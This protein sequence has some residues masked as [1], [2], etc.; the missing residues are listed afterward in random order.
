MKKYLVE[1]AIQN[2][3]QYAGIEP[4]NSTDKNNHIGDYVD[5][6]NSEE[7]IDFAIDYLVDQIKSNGFKVNRDKEGI[8]VYDGEKVIEYYYNFT[9][10][11][12]NVRYLTYIGQDSWGRYT[13]KDE[14]QNIWKLLDCGS[15]R[16]L[17]ET[18][19]DIPYSVSGNSYDGEP[20]FPMHDFN[21]I[22][23]KYD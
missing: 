13:Y 14:N 17:C 5:A 11:P 12:I 21:D 16:R 22:T 19:G 20:E 4:Y 1:N 9:A 15:P 23:V 2:A 10:T 8:T 3:N 7:A 18:R 6:N